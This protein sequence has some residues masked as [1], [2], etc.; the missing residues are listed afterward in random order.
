MGTNLSRLLRLSPACFFILL[1]GLI[2]YQS[3]L[4]D[5]ELAQNMGSVLGPAAYPKLLGIL[6]LGLAILSIFKSGHQSLDL[7][8]DQ[9]EIAHTKPAY[10]LVFLS[11][12]GLLLLTYFLD[13]LGF[14]ITSVLL[15][16]WF[17]FMMGERRW[18]F[19]LVSSVVFPLIV[20]SVFRYGF[21]TVL[22]E[23]V[24]IALSD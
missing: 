23:G 9:S 18:G 1:G 5:V 4:L 3:S 2:V 11:F 16:M 12:A 15:M 14:I 10:H 21:D 8:D 19:L 17:M 7:P 22:P 20:Y 24:L 6:M 13:T